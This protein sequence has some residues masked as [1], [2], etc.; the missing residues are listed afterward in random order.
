MVDALIGLFIVVIVVGIVYYLLKLV[1]NLLP[2][3]GNFKQI[4]NLLLLL[5]CVLFILARALPLLGVHAF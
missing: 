4:A 1:I 2:I 3:E 5:I